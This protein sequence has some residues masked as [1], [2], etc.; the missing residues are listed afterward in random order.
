MPNVPNDV[1]LGFDV[2]VKTLS[3]RKL[4][5]RVSEATSILELKHKISE[6]V[7]IA[8]RDMR[9][10]FQGK[11]LADEYSLDHY[12]IRNDSLVHLTVALKGG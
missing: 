12:G 1:E 3:G 8:V 4:T 5:L 7:E 2:V 9:L 10:V 11:S 6:N